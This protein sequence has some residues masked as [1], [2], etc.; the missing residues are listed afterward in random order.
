MLIAEL[1][2]PLDLIP[3]DGTGELPDALAG[4]I[5]L[6]KARLAEDILCYRFSDSNRTTVDWW[7]RDLRRE[8]R[9]WPADRPFR[10]LLDLRAEQLTVGLYALRRARELSQLRP[11][12]A[13]QTAVVAG[14]LLTARIVG[15]AIRMLPNTYRQRIVLCCETDAIDWLRRRGTMGS[16]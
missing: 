8:L 16:V 7:A 6:T 9:K 13:G 5:G 1:N 11:D 10:L 2:V 15:T 3:D 4:A 14:N 12:M